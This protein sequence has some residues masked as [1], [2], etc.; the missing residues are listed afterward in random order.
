MNV[1]AVKLA[2]RYTYENKDDLYRYQ[3]LLRGE[4]KNRLLALLIKN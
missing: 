2:K 1:F 4:T 3:Y